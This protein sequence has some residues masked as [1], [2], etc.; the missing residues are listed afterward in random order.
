MLNAL[1]RR[2]ILSMKLREKGSGLPIQTGALPW[3]RDRNECVEVLLVTGRKSGRWQIP[4]GW[5]MFGK[6]LATAAAQEALEEAGVEGVIDPKPL[7]SFRHDKQHVLSGPLEVSIVVHSLAVDKE[8]ARWPE[9][10]QRRRKW[11]PLRQ[12]AKQVDS[13]TLSRLILDFTPEA[14]LAG[15]GGRK[16]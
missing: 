12:A 6:S 7:G 4:K 10:Q 15:P 11:F 14:K 3:R 2:L 1:R 16:R 5:P 9:S 8:L 13:E